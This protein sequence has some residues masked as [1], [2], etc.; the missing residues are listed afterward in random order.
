MEWRSRL[1]RF[2]LND[3]SYPIPEIW[4]EPLDP[5]E[6]EAFVRKYR[7]TYDGEEAAREAGYESPAEIWLELL[8][9]DRVK[10]RLRYYR[11]GI[12]VPAQNPTAM[13]ESMFEQTF[14]SLEKVFVRDVS[15][16]ELRIDWEEAA[17]SKAAFLDFEESIVYHGGIP[18]RTTKLRKRGS[19]AALQ[20]LAQNLEKASLDAEKGNRIFS[21][22]YLLRH[23]MKD[24]QS[25][26]VVPDDPARRLARMN[27]R[28]A[29][30]HDEEEEIEP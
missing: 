25:L 4:S 3:G 10:A 23:F 8:A 29:P 17:K 30:K 21:Y 26:P 12:G 1:T 5:P 11:A 15:T 6:L 13:F 20:A 16:N 2:S 19:L 22:N 24:V 27:R 28:I 9:I 18:Q 14:G 7:E